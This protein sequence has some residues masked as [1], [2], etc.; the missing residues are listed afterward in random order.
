MTPLPSP[1][2]VRDLLLERLGREIALRPG[3][4]YV[5]EEGERATLAVYVDAAV[6]TR[7]V[8]IADLP[9]S[10]YAGAAVGLLTSG[11]AE[12]AIADRALPGAIRE[13]LRRLLEACAALLNEDGA[14]TV[15]YYAM[16]APGTVPPTDVSGYA[17]VVG[18]RLDYEVTVAGYG[19]GRLSVVLVG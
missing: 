10:A 4:P 6:R 14:P 17:R 15:R 19:V 16:H 18:R 11:S 3:V 2:A 13:N 12:E 5:P 9:F 8:V 1:K 7:A